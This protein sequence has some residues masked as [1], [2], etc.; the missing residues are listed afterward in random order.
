MNKLKKILIALDD[1]PTAEKVALHGLQLGQQLNAEMALVSIVDTFGLITDGS[2]T[3][4]ELI[5]S[6]TNG[7]KKSHQL[8]LDTVFKG[9]KVWTFV[10][11]GKPFETIIKVAEEWDADLIVIG[12]HGRTGLSHL[13]MG[14][15]AEKIIRHSIKPVF[16]VPTK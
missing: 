14:S 9:Y 13:L 3:P 16:I 15:V 10:E 7:Y 11:E 12:T 6:V 5:E 2:I 8:L 1:G 4:R